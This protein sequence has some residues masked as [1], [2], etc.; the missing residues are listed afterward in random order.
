MRT[1]HLFAG[2]GGGLLADL[3]LGHQPICA[4]EWDTHACQ[5]LQARSDEGWFPGLHVHEGDVRQ[6]DF[7][8]WAGTVDQLC[9]GFPCQDISAAGRGAGI[10]GE[11]SGLV[12]EV[13]RAIDEIRPPLL[14]LENS[15]N[16]RTKGRDVV[17]A[18]LVARGYAWKD[19]K[20]GA[21]D[22]GAGHLRDRWWCL[23]ANADGLRKLRE[24]GKRSDHWGW[25]GHGAGEASTNHHGERGSGDPSKRKPAWKN[26]GRGE[27]DDFAWNQIGATADDLCHRLQVA[28]QRGGLSPADAAAIEAA[29]RHTG[30]YDWSPPDAGLCGVVDG[31]ANRMDR[32]KCAGNGQVPLQAAA[33]WL[34]LSR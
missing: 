16:I 5:V 30:A 33:A 23:A 2:A 20:L 17:I 3:V 34:I 12:S 19:G 21:A 29:A 22:V 9:A 10:E 15:P 4:V 6:F 26:A 8:P 11:R 14:W 1:M 13:F 28:V 24:E 27:A 31:V 7:H 18:A 25:L 32:I